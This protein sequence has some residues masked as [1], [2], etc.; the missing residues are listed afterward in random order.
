MDCKHKRLELRGHLKPEGLSETDLW[1]SDLSLVC[2]DC[3]THLMNSPKDLT[4][5]INIPHPAK[6]DCI[7]PFNVCASHLGGFGSWQCLQCGETGVS[8]PTTNLEV[9]SMV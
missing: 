7:H 8:S 1:I 2:L 3:G 4:R 5:I 9:K 6:K